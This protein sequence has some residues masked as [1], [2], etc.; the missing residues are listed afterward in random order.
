[1]VDRD[2]VI[3]QRIAGQVHAALLEK[4]IEPLLGESPQPRLGGGMP[5]N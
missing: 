4:L 5:A 3:R 1:V 2:G